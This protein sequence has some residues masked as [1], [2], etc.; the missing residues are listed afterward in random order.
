MIAPSKIIRKIFV[1]CFCISVIIF[2]NLSAQQ[3]KPPASSRIKKPPLN[4]LEN[5]FQL[6]VYGSLTY[7]VMKGEYTGPVTCNYCSF[8]KSGTGFSVPVGITMNIPITDESSIYLRAGMLSASVSFQGGRKDTLR[9]TREVGE[10]FDD[11]TLD[12]QMTTIDIILRLIAQED[13]FRILA[14]PT[15]GFIKKSNVVLLETE[16]GTGKQYTIEKNE[17]GG[18]VDTR[19]GFLLGLEY[20]FIPISHIYI[21][22]ALI[23]DYGLNSIS[24]IH[25][26][27]P[28]YYNFTLSVAYQF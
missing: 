2:S 6:G 28:L 21:L 4:R 1:I 26:L 17:L 10:M 18:P 25:S 14:G 23:F 7:D 5:R 24:T 3:G 11:L 12:V 15:F 16:T 27:R 8:V 13:G 22:P 9:S 20:A 19:Y